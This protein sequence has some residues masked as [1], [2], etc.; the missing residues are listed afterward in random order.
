TTRAG[1]AIT[2]RFSRPVFPGET[3]TTDLW[4]DGNAVLF[5]AR[6]GD[7]VVLDNGRAEISP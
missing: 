2:G 7:R 1:C 5:R 4:Q 3:V 6:V